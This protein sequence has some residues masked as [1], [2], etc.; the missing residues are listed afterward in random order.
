MVARLR[1]ADAHK[2]ST[3]RFVLLKLTTDRHKA[4]RG[5]FATAELLVDV[6]P[7]AFFDNSLDLL[8]IRLNFWICRPSAGALNVTLTLCY[9]SAVFS[10]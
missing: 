8:L 1:W 3:Q 10:H 5:L 9:V 7:S 6:E 4:S 2:D